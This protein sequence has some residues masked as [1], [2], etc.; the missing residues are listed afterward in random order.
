MNLTRANTT[1][2]G[3]AMPAPRNASVIGWYWRSN[4]DSEKHWRIFLSRYT[5]TMHYISY[6]TSREIFS[7]FSI[8]IIQQLYIIVLPE[9]RSSWSRNIPIPLLSVYCRRL[10]RTSAPDGTRP[11]QAEGQHR[12][13]AIRPWPMVWRLYGMPLK[14]IINYYKVLFYN[15]LYWNFKLT[16]YLQVN[17]YDE[18]RKSYSSTW[19]EVHDAILC[20][21]IKLKMKHLIKNCTSYYWKKYVSLV[22]SARTW[23]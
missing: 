3:G 18:H 21:S 2:G 17:C 10:N 14:S 5:I 8:K 22:E 1:R 19:P 13:C 6:T 15:K 11:S 12:Q 9:A 20:D 16:N 23:D 7:S 4:Q